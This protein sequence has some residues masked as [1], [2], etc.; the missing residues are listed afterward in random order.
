MVFG[1]GI[2][3]ENLQLA[4]SHIQPVVERADLIRLRI[5]LLRAGK[6][7]K[8]GHCAVTVLGILA[9]TLI[10]LPPQTT[11]DIGNNAVQDFSIPFI[12]VEVIVDIGPQ[13]AS[14]LRTTVGICIL[15]SGQ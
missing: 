6:R 7:K 1:G 12:P 3:V 2:G 9:I 10:E 5:R 15:K 8:L 14:R 11:R 13:V 4:A